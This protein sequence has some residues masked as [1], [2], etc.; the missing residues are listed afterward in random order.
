[1][2]ELAAGDPLSM[3]ELT[4]N[5]LARRFDTVI[6]ATP[7]IQGRL[8]G[9]RTTVE[10]FRHAVGHSGIHVSTCVFGWDIVQD[11]ALL[12]GGRLRYT[13]KHTGMGDIALRPDLATLRPAGWLERTAVCLADAVE[14]DGTPTAVS[15]RALLRAELARWEMARMRASTGTEL[16]FYLY[17]GSPR[18][19]RAR[20]YRGL[21]PTTLSPADYSLYE[22]DEFEPFSADL[23]QR[24]QE[25]GIEVEAAQLEWGL[26]QWE[27]TLVHTSPLEMAD[28]H[29]LY[30]LATR[31]LAAR[32]GFTATF[33]A[34]PFDGG[35][36]SSCHVHL[37]V[38]GHD[39][40]PLFWDGSAEQ[41]LSADLRQAIGGSLARAGELMAWYAPTVN[42]Y[43]RIRSHDA[44]GWGLSWGI[45]HRFC[46]VRVV[47]HHPEELRLEFRLPG[48]DANPYLVLAG[49]LA[50]VR[51]GLARKVDPG[52]A[53]VGNPH[54]T[55]PEGIPLHL[56]DAVAAFR[57]SL[58]AR[59]TFGDEVI[60]HHAALGT[61][62][63]HR[64]LDAVTD[65]ER[66]RYFELI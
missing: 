32:A 21:T 14:A 50:S 19:A 6:V 31:T 22:G 59:A 36:G 60:D 35:P 53:T 44:A 47:G 26:G 11:A 62:E 30:K 46:S 1:M 61:F 25:T 7:D 33:M 64:F 54:E 52:P 45:D 10:G 51:D 34:K 27:T 9:R 66:E 41:H 48:A 17:R 56:G 12:A 13:G 18:Q 58:F 42:S 49:L 2:S 23:R 57:E 39:G 3:N 29:A 8:I 24:L 63:W 28:R 43:R 5:E 38:C 20:G 4:M 37:S 15:P 40:A 65:W 55:A 16:E